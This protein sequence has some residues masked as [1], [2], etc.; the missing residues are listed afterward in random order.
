MIARMVSRL[1]GALVCVLWAVAAQA[2]GAILETMDQLAGKPSPPTF[3]A[4]L[5][6]K[7][8]ISATL[9]APRTQA[10]TSTC[11]SWSVTYAAASQAARRNGLGAAVVLSPAFTYN[12]VANDHTCR[13]ATSTSATLDVLKNVGALPIDEYVFDAGWCG[14]QPTAAEKQRAARYRIKNWSRFDATDLGMVK[15]Q[16]ARGVPVIFAMRVGA[17]LTGL[18]GDTVLNDDRDLGGSHAM[19][20][21]GFDDDRQAFR[22]QNSWGRSWGEDGLGWFGYDFWKRN[23]KVGFVID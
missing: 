22:I 7:I 12:I 17:A 4:P 18:R 15:Q 1:L 5:P 8:D 16:I 2:Q 10:D 3:R 20:A 9:P 14:R 11:T 21:V 23:V 13:N 6:R 19:V